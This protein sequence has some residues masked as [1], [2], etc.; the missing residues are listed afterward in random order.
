MQQHVTPAPRRRMI[1]GISGATGI[2]FGLRILQVLRRLDIETHLVMSKPGERTL[3]YETELK[4]RDVR[5]MA[6][7]NY[8]DADVGAAI[9]SG[10]FRTMGMIVAPCSVRSLSAIATGNT[11]G[12]LTRAADVCLKERR[13][14]VLMFRETPL[15]AGHIRAM[16]QA[17]ENGAIVF[18]PVPAFYDRPA[19]LDEMVNHT[20]GR[21]LD[22]YDLDA[23][24]FNRWGVQPEAVPPDDVCARGDA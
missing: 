9:A 10:S 23:G 7:F 14:V 21:V 20:V 15:H 18:P 6:D 8:L 19:S 11:D 12:L 2:I 3:A 22:L 5:A 1:V 17:T 16:A 13:R 24:L 4:V